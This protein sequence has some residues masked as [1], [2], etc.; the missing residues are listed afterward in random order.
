MSEVE[1]FLE[2]IPTSVVL[3][4]IV[5]RIN[6][7]ES[8]GRGG[9]MVVFGSFQFSWFFWPTYATSIISASLGMA[10]VLKVRLSQNISIDQ[11]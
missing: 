10:K 3:S 2:S 11:T 4:Y 9:S 1:Y 7:S 8:N 6:K 5:N